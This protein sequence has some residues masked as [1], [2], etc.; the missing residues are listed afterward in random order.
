MRPKKYKKKIKPRILESGL[1][2]VD[3]KSKI[4]KNTLF[5]TLIKCAGAISTTLRLCNISRRDFYMVLKKDP[6]FK[7]EYEGV[8]DY[9]INIVESEVIR[10]SVD[11]IF[12]PVFYNGILVGYTREYSDY[13]LCKL[14][15]AY[16]KN[17]R[18]PKGEVIQIPGLPIAVDFDSAA[19]IESDDEDKDPE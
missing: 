12:K 17:W 19:D 11:G 5:K 1:L 16:R 18:Y 3:T 8:R 13:L 7:A 14:L 6:K 2:R 4:F 15:S 9:A 10:R